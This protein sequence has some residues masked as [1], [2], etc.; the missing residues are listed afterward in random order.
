MSTDNGTSARDIFN[1]INDYSF[2]KPEVYNVNEDKISLEDSYRYAKIIV[3]LFIVHAIL[4]VIQSFSLEDHSTGVNMT[5]PILKNV[6]YLRM[7]VTV[8][9]VIYIG[10]FMDSFVQQVEYSQ[11]EMLVPEYYNDYDIVKFSYDNVKRVRT[12]IGFL[13]FIGIIVMFV[14]LFTVFGTEYWAKTGRR[15]GQKGYS[16]TGENFLGFHVTEK[17]AAIVPFVLFILLI[18]MGVTLD[19]EKIFE[20]N[21]DPLVRTYSHAKINPNPENFEDRNSGKRRNYIIACLVLTYFI[22]CGIS[23]TN[24]VCSHV[25]TERKFVSLSSQFFNDYSEILIFTRASPAWTIISGIAVLIMMGKLE[26][27]DMKQ[28]DYYD[29][30]VSKRQQGPTVQLPGGKTPQ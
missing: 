5:F 17:L 10:L 1:R 3:I 15:T 14:S 13:I 11:P 2:F 18:A 24:I 28:F 26:E 20:E 25:M 23:F 29:K 27:Q 19:G 8:F 6:M 21:I 9:L 12:F 30:L 4:S 7:A 22:I 16:L